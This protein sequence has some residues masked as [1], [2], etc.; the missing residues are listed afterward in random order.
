MKNGRRNRTDD[1]AAGVNSGSSNPLS[2]NL[3]ER[4]LYDDDTGNDT[5]NS[6]SSGGDSDGNDIGGDTTAEDLNRIFAEQLEQSFRTN[7]ESTESN[8][9]FEPSSDGT[10]T[11]SGSTRRT[12]GRG[13]KQRDRSDGGNGDNRASADEQERVVSAPPRAVNISKL[14]GDVF[15]LSPAQQKEII[16]GTIETA[17]GLPASWYGAHWRLSKAES[18]DITKS[19]LLCLA[20]LP[21]GE[22]KKWLALINKY[23]PW[24]SLSLLLGMTTY[25]RIQL[26]RMKLEYEKRQREQFGGP[27]SGQSSEPVLPNSSDGNDAGVRPNGK[28]GT[29]TVDPLDFQAPFTHLFVKPN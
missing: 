13:R 3:A 17:F 8:Q 22:A 29:D 18:E 4:I 21:K 15:K 5:G 6:A 10:A 20:T 27:A 11:G 28:S 9:Q 12:R 1:S 2:A 23:A 7:A 16:Q 24:V 19:V 14:F 26:T 25:P